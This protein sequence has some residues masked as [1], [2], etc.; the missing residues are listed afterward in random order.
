MPRVDPQAKD[1]T[2]RLAQETDASEAT[3]TEIE[4]VGGELLDPLVV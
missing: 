2:Q 1:R 4:T 3:F